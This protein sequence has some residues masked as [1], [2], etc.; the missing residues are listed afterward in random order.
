MSSPGC[1]ARTPR[2]RRDE[3]RGPAALA[4]P[5]AIGAG[6]GGSITTVHAET[7]EL[8][9]DRLALLVLQ[10]G[11]PLAYLEGRAHVARS[12]DAVVQIGRCAFSNTAPTRR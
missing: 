6:H 2:P 12:T 9:M 1:H 4:S 7:A 11:T 8:A 10:A 3:L 5:K